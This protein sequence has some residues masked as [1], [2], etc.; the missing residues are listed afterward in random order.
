MRGRGRLFF[1]FYPAAPRGPPQRGRRQTP[2]SGCSRTWFAMGVS[3][4]RDIS[5]FLE[6]NPVMI[7]AKEV[8]AAHRARYFWGNLPGM[9]RLVKERPLTAMI[10]DKL[11]LQDC[12]EHGRTAKF[13]KV[14]TI[15]TRSNSIK[16][17]KD[18]HFPVY[19]NEKED[20]L[21]CTEMERVFGF[22]VHYT[23]VSNMSRLARQRL[24]G[25]SWSV[26]VIRHLFAPLKEYFACV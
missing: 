1:E 11:D 24:L 9:N 8:S 25:R 4:K 26:P 21:W 2:S 18:Q 19:M 3:D 16:Q 15:T 10:N 12:L 5:R 20:I 6:C 14:R 23:D 7:D 17:G 22:P 13:G